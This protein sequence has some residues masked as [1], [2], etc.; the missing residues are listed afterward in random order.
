MDS[1]G[2]KV[3]TFIDMTRDNMEYGRKVHEDGRVIP[4]CRIT[5]FNP[6]PKRVE[7]DY[8]EEEWKVIDADAVFEE[9]ERFAGFVDCDAAPH[10]YRAV[11]KRCL[12]P[13]KM[14]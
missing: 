9:G 10:G 11:T 8:I 6:P 4:F 1:M 13:V 3:E 12:R 2:M 14:K 5:Y 7:W